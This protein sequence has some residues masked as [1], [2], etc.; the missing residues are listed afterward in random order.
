MLHVDTDKRENQVPISS[1]D[2]RFSFLNGMES[3]ISFPRLP[4][5]LWPDRDREP[6]SP[7][8]YSDFW[9]FGLK[10]STDYDLL[11]FEKWSSEDCGVKFFGLGHSVFPNPYFNSGVFVPFS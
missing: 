10:N 6:I 2:R 11:R 3:L 4:T 5:F 8:L 9:N 7:G 1:S